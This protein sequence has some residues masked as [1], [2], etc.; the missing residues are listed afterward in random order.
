MDLFEGHR[1]LVA[2]LRGLEPD[3]ALATGQALVEAGIGMIE[4]PL[5]SPDP[6]ADS[7]DIYLDGVLAVSDLKFREAT[8][9]LAI[10]SSTSDIGVAPGNSTS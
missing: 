4:V 1:P 3:L 2:I 8:E 10:S 6:L 9:F 7:V 5:N